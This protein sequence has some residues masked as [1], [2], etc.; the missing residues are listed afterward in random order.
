MVQ[1]EKLDYRLS[2]YK[3]KC[4]HDDGLKGALWKRYKVRHLEPYKKQQCEVL[5]LTPDGIKY[6]TFSI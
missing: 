5:T 2:N 1:G 4:L 3:G 6:F